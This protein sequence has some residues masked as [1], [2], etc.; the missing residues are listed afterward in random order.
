MYRASENFY[1]SI[2]IQNRQL[3]II[4]LTFHLCEEAFTVDDNALLLKLLIEE[5]LPEKKFDEAARCYTEMIVSI[6]T[7]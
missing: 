4:N 3:L 2:F 5:L 1:F 6:K 7:D